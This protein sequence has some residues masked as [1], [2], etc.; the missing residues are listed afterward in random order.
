MK[1]IEYKLTPKITDEIIH[2]RFSCFN[3]SLNY[4]KDV[5]SARE[6]YDENSFHLSFF[7]DGKF[8]GYTRLTPCPNNYMNHTSKDKI[9]IPNDETTFEMGRT[10]VLPEYRG[11]KFDSLILLVGLHISETLGYK[12]AIGN[13][14]YEAHLKMPTSN[15]WEFMNIIADF[16]MPFSNKGYHTFYLIKCDLKKT[17][18]FRKQRLIEFKKWFADNGYDFNLA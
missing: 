16:A 5:N 3:E 11:I 12:I 17:N 4:Y 10:I 8:A 9:E 15:G 6:V 14:S 18:E 1:K 13:E 2:H 7:V